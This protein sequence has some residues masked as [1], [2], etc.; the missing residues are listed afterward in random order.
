M[1]RL[2]CGKARCKFTRLEGAPAQ[3]KQAGHGVRLARGQ[4]TC[5]R[6]CDN[7]ALGGKHVLQAA[8]RGEFDLHAA[9]LACRRQAVEDEL[10]CDAGAGLRT[11]YESA[12]QLLGFALEQRLDEQRGFVA[13]ALGPT[14]AL[15]IA[16]E[17]PARW[18]TLGRAVLIA[19]CHVLA[20]H[21]ERR[22]SGV[23]FGSMGGLPHAH[24]VSGD[25]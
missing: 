24:A 18:P 7:G 11:R 17:K 23:G 8:N 14:Q 2:E 3:I 20:V 15:A 21:W 5:G 4:L 22:E 12:R 6:L 9:V 13:R 16:R 19:L 1:T 10:E 25:R